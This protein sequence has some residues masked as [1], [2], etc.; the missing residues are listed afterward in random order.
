MEHFLYIVQ[1]KECIWFVFIYNISNES[2]VSYESSTNY[3][4]FW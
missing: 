4:L 2:E 3:T 1:K